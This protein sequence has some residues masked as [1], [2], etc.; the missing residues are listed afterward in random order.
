ML[1]PIILQVL[2]QFLSHKPI[3]LNACE[4][5]NTLGG[6]ISTKYVNVQ[7][8]ECEMEVNT[9]GDIIKMCNSLIDLYGD[10]KPQKQLINVPSLSPSASSRKQINSWQWDTIGSPV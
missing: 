1:T 10:L 9:A 8:S 4:A 7:T 6:I 5:L 3:V 2:L